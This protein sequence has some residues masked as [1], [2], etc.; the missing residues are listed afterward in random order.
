MQL[1]H[2]VHAKGENVENVLREADAE[3]AGKSAGY[4]EQQGHEQ[5][6]ETD[7]ETP[8]VVPPMIPVDAEPDAEHV[9]I[10]LHPIRLNCTNKK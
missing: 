9:C 6:M 2:S 10:S 7:V 4:D 5:R 1:Y 8:A 3:D